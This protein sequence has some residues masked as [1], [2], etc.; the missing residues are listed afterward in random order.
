M[1]DIKPYDNSMDVPLDEVQQPPT[2]SFDTTL[3]GK[4]ND[5]VTVPETITSSPT[6]YNTNIDDSSKTSSPTGDTTVDSTT[7]WWDTNNNG[8]Y[9]EWEMNVEKQDTNDFISNSDSDVDFDSAATI[10]P[11]SA[12]TIPATIPPGD[13]STETPTTYWWDTNN[14]LSLIHI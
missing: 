9:D 8:V 10:P 12:D 4:N 11:T 2:P 13:T 5:T 7:Y 1:I 6:D 3:A 14:N